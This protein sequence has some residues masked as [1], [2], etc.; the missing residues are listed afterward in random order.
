MKLKK[1]VRWQLG[2]AAGESRSDLN[3]GLARLP[4]LKGRGRELR[5]IAV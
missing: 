3:S 5:V 4:C 1:F 2:K